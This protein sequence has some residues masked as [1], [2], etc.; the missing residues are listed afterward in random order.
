MK[1]LILPLL[2]AL[3]ACAGQSSEVSRPENVEVPEATTAAAASEDAAALAREA[4]LDLATADLADLQKAGYEI[5]TRDGQTLYCRKDNETGSR[6]RKN[7]YCLTRQQL[8]EIEANTKATMRDI[9][10]G[11]SPKSN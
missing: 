2:A 5:E 10:Q 6:V 7:Q 4:G 11:A 9:T 8:Q 3:S 1:S